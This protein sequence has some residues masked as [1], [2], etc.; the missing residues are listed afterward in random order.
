MYNKGTYIIWPYDCCATSGGS[1]WGI[2]ETILI[3]DIVNLLKS[4]NRTKLRKLL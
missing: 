3:S 1:L 2:P 4:L